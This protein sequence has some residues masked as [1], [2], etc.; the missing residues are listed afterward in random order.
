ML[1]THP[2]TARF[3]STSW[4]AAS[5]P[6]SRRRRW[7]TAPPS[8]FRRTGRRHPRGGRD[9]RDLARVPRARGP[10]GEGQDAARVRGQ[11]GARRRAPRSTDAPRAGPPHRRDGH[12][13]LPAAAAHRLQ[14]HRRRLGLDERPARPARTSRSTSPRAGCAA[15]VVEPAALPRT[16]SRRALLPRRPVGRHAQT[17]ARETPALDAARM[18]GLILGSPEFQRR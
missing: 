3:I 6:T 1:A 14:G 11:R 10:R 4:R 5:W 17:L 18:A 8:T 9:D 7:S 16:R 15:C 13:A 12:A 2:S